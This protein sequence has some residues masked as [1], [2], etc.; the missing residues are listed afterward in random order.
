MAAPPT[1]LFPIDVCKDCVQLQFNFA[2][3]LAFDGSF[4]YE[5]SVFLPMAY[6]LLLGVAMRRPCRISE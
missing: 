4:V 1:S 3:N 2:C 5:Q 6:N